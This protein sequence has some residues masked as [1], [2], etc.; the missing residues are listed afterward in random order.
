MERAQDKENGNPSQPEDTAEPNETE[1]TDEPELKLP[2][3]IR[4]DP[5][6]GDKGK[7]L[8]IEEWATKRKNKDA[9]LKFF[10]IGP[11][12]CGLL[13]FSIGL[14]IFL[15]GNIAGIGLF[16]IGIVVIAISIG[17][18]AMGAR[19]PFCI[20]EN[21]FSTPFPSLESRI[22]HTESFISWREVSLISLRAD[23][24]SAGALLFHTGKKHPVELNFLTLSDPYQVMLVM[25]KVVPEKLSERFNEFIIREPGQLIKQDHLTNWPV[26]MRWIVFLF[27]GIF[28]ILIAIGIFGQVLSEGGMESKNIFPFIVLFLLSLAFFYIS[29]MPLDYYSQREL[30]QRRATIFQQGIQFKVTIFGTLLKR[31]Q[32]II[33]WDCIRSVEIKLNPSYY[34]HQAMI[35][36]FSGERFLIPFEIYRSL[37][38]NESFKLADGKFF[39][40][41]GQP[42]FQII[43]TWQ[44]KYSFGWYE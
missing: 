22:H 6:A 32:P 14:L 27:L 36:T 43:D 40:I 29:I 23:F 18:F 28:M 44:K 35:V 21:G 9:I 17:T 34:N 8:Y 2:D 15:T 42:D 25:N 1:A 24:S 7:L 11:L 4:P 12:I 39:N 26:D 20:Y 13:I 16:V 37:Q 30:I 41:T 5:G 31:I 19:L 10:W 3:W 38:K 33:T